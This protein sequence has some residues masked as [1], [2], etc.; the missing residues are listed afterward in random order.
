MPLQ[1]VIALMKIALSSL[2]LSLDYHLPYSDPK[3][4]DNTDLVSDEAYLNTSK[5]I[6]GEIHF[7]SFDIIK[8]S[9]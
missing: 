5:Q 1:L 9:I 7:T 6:A 4:A 2:M 3:N 8:D